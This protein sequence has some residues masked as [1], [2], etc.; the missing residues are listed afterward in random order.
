MP[1]DLSFL[2]ELLSNKSIWGVNLFSVGLADLVKHYFREL[3]AGPGAVWATL[4]KYLG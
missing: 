3:T 2:D 4:E 1:E